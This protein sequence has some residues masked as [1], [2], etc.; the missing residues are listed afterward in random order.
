M[1][2]GVPG[3]G[4]YKC[5]LMRYKDFREPNKTD[6]ILMATSQCREQNKT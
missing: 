6:V 5:F 1:L 4:K 2:A 3:L